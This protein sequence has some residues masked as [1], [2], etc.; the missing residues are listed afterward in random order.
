MMITAHDDNGSDIWAVKASKSNL[1]FEPLHLFIAKKGHP[2]KITETSCIQGYKEAPSLQ[3]TP[4]GSILRRNWV[5]KAV[6][7]I[8]SNRKN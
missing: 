4:V 6:G 1:I 8:L 7:H 3:K 2:L 5:V